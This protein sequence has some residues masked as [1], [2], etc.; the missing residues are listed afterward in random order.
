MKSI[1]H[2]CVWCLNVLLIIIEMG[3]ST[4]P[5]A[6]QE[7]GDSRST[8]R[9][10]Q[11]SGGGSRHIFK[12]EPLQGGGNIVITLRY[13]A[14]EDFENHDAIGFNVVD[15]ADSE[16]ATSS[17]LVGDEQGD[18][19][20]AQMT[21]NGQG[22]YTIMVFNRSEKPITYALA[23]LGGT[24]IDEL[25]Q[26]NAVSAELDDSA[27]E[28]ADLDPDV[29][30][31]VRARKLTGQLVTLAQRHYIRVEV[32]G[33]DSSVG[34]RMTYHPQ[35]VPALKGLV[36]FWV[37][38]EDGVR[39]FESGAHPT[40]VAIATGFP[41]EIN[42]KDNEL[43]AGF[44][45]SGN[46]VYQVVVYNQSTIPATYEIEVTGAIFEDG[47]GY[48]LESQVAGIEAGLLTRSINDPRLPQI[49]IEPVIT[50]DDTRQEISGILKRR[51]EHHYLG[52][53]AD[54]PSDKIVLTLGFEPRY[55]E[56]VAA[57]I[58]FHVI[59]ALGMRK[60]I[61]GAKPEE[62]DLATGTRIQFGPDKGLLRAAFQPSAR[63]RY[64]V[65]VYND[66]ERRVD[67]NIQVQNGFLDDGT[68]PAVHPGLNK[69]P[70]VEVTATPPAPPIVSVADGAKT[71]RG[72]LV[73][74]R[75]RHYFGVTPEYGNVTVTLIMDVEPK[76]IDA[77]AGGVNF[78]VLREDAIRK[79]IEGEEAE[80]VNVAAGS[81]IRFNEHK[82]K[83]S[84]TFD[85]GGTSRYTIIVYN[86]TPIEV[87]YTITVDNGIMDD[88][89][90][91]VIADDEVE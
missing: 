43:L 73:R 48:S 61:E 2:R 62:V 72:K 46:G 57:G 63:G 37:L 12:V 27:L 36:N 91:S 85:P 7:I 65:I 82:G 71:V 90:A 3:V 26:T 22:P 69:Q 56:V 39:R 31:K 8:N 42:E 83:L 87:T 19:Q 54:I 75:E 24:L 6:A 49:D 88:G 9:V 52:V 50:V 59:D 29:Y 11:L 64:A 5:T 40:E 13:D 21:D 15:I 58:G 33:R 30:A 14:G 70:A 81:R 68:V 28:S 35:N 55:D 41:S 76:Y 16:L 38:D 10:G 66:T 25:G 78:L 86:L 84:A 60:V 67:Y 45:A 51:Y 34:L 17:Y 80:S 77:V 23:A 4:L 1:F 44:T 20:R 18:S 53:I 32:A 79:V 47:F 89:G 74:E